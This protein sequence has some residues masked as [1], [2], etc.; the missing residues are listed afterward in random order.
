M[1]ATKMGLPE[2]LKLRLTGP[3]GYPMKACK[4]R[5]ST[6]IGV[7]KPCKLCSR[8]KNYWWIISSRQG[9]VGWFFLHIF[10]RSSFVDFVNNHPF[11]VAWVKVWVICWGGKS[12]E[13]KVYCT[14]QFLGPGYLKENASWREGWGWAFC[15]KCF[16]SNGGK[17]DALCFYSLRLVN[18]AVKALVN[19]A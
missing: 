16:I 18:S 9:M 1:T 6:K 12:Q 13:R 7:L 14:D 17:W 11:C 3:T 15:R 19:K 2:R 4:L 8:G 5:D 10:R